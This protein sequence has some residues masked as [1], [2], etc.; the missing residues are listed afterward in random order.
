MQLL[1]VRLFW[2]YL[3]LMFVSSLFVHLHPDAVFV[4][5]CSRLQNRALLE[6]REASHVALNQ[7]I[8]NFNIKK[9]VV[10]S[11]KCPFIEQTVKIDQND[12]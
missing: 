4:L 10:S 7:N 1:R 2:V 8:L 12:R 6:E 5:I 11:T 3:N 9:E